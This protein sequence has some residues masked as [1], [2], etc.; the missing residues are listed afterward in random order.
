MSAIAITVAVLTQSAGI[1]GLVGTSVSIEDGKP[2]AGPPKIQVCMVSEDEGYT[3]SGASMFPKARITV[4][5]IA[6]SAISAELI[7]EAVK[8]AL[9]DF[10]GDV[11]VEATTY[12]A[13]FTKAGSEYADRNDALTTFRKMIDYFV[14]WKQANG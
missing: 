12:W 2:E 11:T 1:T 6:P 14:D 7:G 13:N 9:N 4:E 5:C 8:I 3:L 10:T